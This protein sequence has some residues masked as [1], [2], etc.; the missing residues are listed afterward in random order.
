MGDLIGCRLEYFVGKRHLARMNAALA[1]KTKTAGETRF[2]LETALIADIGERRVVGEHARLARRHAQRK[3]GLLDRRGLAQR[4]AQRLEQV[5]QS[6][7][8]TFHARMRA[9]QFKRAPQCARRFDIFSSKPIGS[10][11]PFARSAAS[12]GCSHVVGK[13]IRLTPGLHDGAGG[14]ISFEMR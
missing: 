1:D 4:D 11:T 9:G 5:A 10:L 12:S 7:L 13:L 14:E 3:H 8:Q 2:G 6:K